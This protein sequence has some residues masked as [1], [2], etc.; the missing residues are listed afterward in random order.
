MFGTNVPKLMKMITEEL[1]IDEKFRK[2]EYE[3]KFYEMDELL[4][5]EIERLQEQEEVEKK[6]AE[7]E[8][9]EALRQRKEY[10]TLVT[11]QIKEH[12]TDIGC[13]VFMP[14]INRDIYKK[15]TDPAEKFEL[16]AKERKIT[17]IPKEHH[18][19]ILLDCPNAWPK[20]VFDYIL[21]KDVIINAWKLAEGELKEPEVVL[22]EFVNQIA[23]KQAIADEA[24][25]PIPDAFEKELIEPFTVPNT[26]V[27]VLGAWTPENRTTN[28]ALI[29]LYF[30]S[31]S[32]C[33]I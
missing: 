12:I 18:E 8:A 22:K 7:K 2:G 10:L 5:E 31:V 25:Q 21:K 3:R 14:N 16:T 9:A 23:N 30:R 20:E 15:L 33:V 29:Y 6:I 13:T 4:P 32:E 1:E 28:A 27:T 19:V 26:S 11:D 17:N 24:G